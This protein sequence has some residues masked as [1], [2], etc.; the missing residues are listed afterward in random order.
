[1]HPHLS[2]SCPFR[3]RECQIELVLRETQGLKRRSALSCGEQEQRNLCEFFISQ[4]S[5]E[6]N[7]KSAI[8]PA[9]RVLA[10]Y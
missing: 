3:N 10:L 4:E 1:M 9:I 2:E 5:E 8:S 6:G 7:W